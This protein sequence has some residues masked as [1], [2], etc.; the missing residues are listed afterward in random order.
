MS[1]TADAAAVRRGAG[2]FALGERGV[3]EVTGGDRA[4]WLNG[5]LSN[6]VADLTGL[7]DHSG[8]YALL[9]SPKGRIVADLHVLA[10]GDRYWLE[11]DGAHLAAVRMR[12]ERYII[13]DDV[14]LDD[15]SDR[16]ARLGIE[17]PASRGIVEK[18]CGERVAL[19]PECGG[20]FRIADAAVVIAAY[21]WSGE[22]AFQL[23]V[24]REA[25][26]RVVA[27][28]REAGG[29]ALTLCDDATL[30]VLRIEAG[31]PRLGAELDEDVFPA[32]AGLL[33]RAV[34]LTKGCFTGQEIVARLESRG[35]VNHRLVGLRFDGGPPA[36]GASLANAEGR[37]I[38]EVTSVGISEALGPIGLGYVRLPFDAPET[39]LR[40]ETEGAR[41]AALP[42]LDGA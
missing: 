14:A 16:W 22:T 2:L 35:N 29:A 4:R 6:E 21:G 33:A 9:L 8:C 25:E 36:V 26:P 31:V 12:L 39:P 24:P 23:F 15:V 18:A 1:A 17:G 19:A 42:L 38:G 30:E 3:L 40:A 34:S 5:M 32:E 41:V 10:R 28:L 13:A 37:E 11:L 20:E 7:P 27:A